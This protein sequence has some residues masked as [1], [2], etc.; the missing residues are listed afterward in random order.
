MWV[1]TWKVERDP[2]SAF[3]AFPI[4]LLWWLA[5]ILWST[6]REPVWWIR[7]I[8]HLGCIIQD[9]FCLVHS[10]VRVA[11]YEL[12]SQC[13]KKNHLVRGLTLKGEQYNK[14][15]SWDHSPLLTWDTKSK[16]IF[17]YPLLPPCLA[18]QKF[19]RLTPLRLLQIWFSST[20]IRRHITCTCML[21]V[22][23]LA[24]FHIALSKQLPLWQSPQNGLLAPTAWA[25]STCAVCIHSAQN[26]WAIGNILRGSTALPCILRCLINAVHI[27]HVSACF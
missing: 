8:D 26:T 11:H 5:K 23:T 9:I 27:L 12:L 10:S 3:A 15:S 25:R 16:E 24:Y 21:V 2:A 4:W 22:C 20:K 19:K 13:A 14:I 7:T 18:C 1:I 17:F 6:T